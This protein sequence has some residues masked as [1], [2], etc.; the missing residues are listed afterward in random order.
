VV[1]AEHKAKLQLPQDPEPAL[2]LNLFV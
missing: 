1:G 2:L